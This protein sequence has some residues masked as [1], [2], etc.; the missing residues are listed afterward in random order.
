M[1]DIKGQNYDNIANCCIYSI[2]HE[3][4]KAT[5]EG[6]FRSMLERSLKY[7]KEKYMQFADDIEM[8]LE[9]VKQF[10]LE[11]VNEKRTILFDEMLEVIEMN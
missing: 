11:P 7:Y 1:I 5:Y 8:L 3:E 9:D 6:T 10:S 4:H 2:G